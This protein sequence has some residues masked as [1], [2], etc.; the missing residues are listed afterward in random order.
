MI[1]GGSFYEPEDITPC[2]YCE[3][4]AKKAQGELFEKLAAIEH[5]RW[6]DWQRYMH[7]QCFRAINGNLV[8]PA[9]LVEQWERQIATPY[10]ALSEKEKNSDRDQVRRY[11]DLVRQEQRR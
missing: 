3:I 5:E 8:I 6:A 9:N 4:D 11:W 7:E 2:P 1:C 10:A